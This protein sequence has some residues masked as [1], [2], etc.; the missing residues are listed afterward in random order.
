M[1]LQRGRLGSKPDREV[2]SPDVYEILAKHD[3]D[4]GQL[5]DLAQEGKLADAAILSKLT[6]IEATDRHATTKLISA[7]VVTV[8]TTIGGVIGTVAAMRPGQPPPPAARS[9]LD[10]KL[11]A[12][13]PIHDPGSRAE[14]MSRV[15]EAEPK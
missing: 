6:G 8:I 13:R 15:F 7:L 12:C 14:C 11:D 5:K 3:E 9:E 2:F 4:I 1:T 10:V